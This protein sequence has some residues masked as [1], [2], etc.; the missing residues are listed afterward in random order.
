MEIQAIA[1]ETPITRKMM[2]NTSLR[3]RED[4][5]IVSALQDQAVCAGKAA[6]GTIGA[7][8]AMQAMG[9]TTQ[10]SYDWRGLRSWLPLLHKL[11]I[12]FDCMR[13][14]RSCLQ[15]LIFDHTALVCG[16]DRLSRAERTR[17]IQMQGVTKHLPHISSMLHQMFRDSREYHDA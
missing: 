3:R 11:M 1:A 13:P 4:L 10:W 8:V 6:M 2:G 14:D 17:L 16:D 5:G 9:A 7:T 12:F 15:H